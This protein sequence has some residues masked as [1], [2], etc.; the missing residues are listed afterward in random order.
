MQIGKSRSL[1]QKRVVEMN[2]KVYSRANHVESVNDER[3]KK[4]NNYVDNDSSYL[5]RHNRQSLF[6]CV[7]KAN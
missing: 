5:Q 2:G 4:E 3:E 1:K 6:Q 7:R